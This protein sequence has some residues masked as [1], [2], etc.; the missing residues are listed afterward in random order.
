MRWP[1][2][3]AP[4]P[5]PPAMPGAEART[6]TRAFAIGPLTGEARI[7]QAKFRLEQ[8]AGHLAIHPNVPEWKK[9]EFRDEARLLAMGLWVGK[10]ISDAEHRDVLRRCG[11]GG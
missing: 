9:A 6:V 1:W 8:I 11:A 2:Q 10:V 5:A 3:K 4:A 7:E